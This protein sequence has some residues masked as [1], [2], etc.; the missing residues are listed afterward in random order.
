MHAVVVLA[1]V[2]VVV[3]GVVIVVGVVMVVDRERPSS[4]IRNS[5][6]TRAHWTRE[7]SKVFNSLHGPHQCIKRSATSVNIYHRT[8]NRKKNCAVTKQQGTTSHKHQP[9][10]ARHQ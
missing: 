4:N 5:D 1:V 6:Y 3:V 2:V 10:Y 9:D 8:C 7:D